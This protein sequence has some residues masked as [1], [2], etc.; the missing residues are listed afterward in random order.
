M[1][2]VLAWVKSNVLIVVFV[3][4]VLIVLPASYV[5]SRAWG[6]KVRTAQETKAGAEM[7]KITGARVDYSL[8][9]FDPAAQPVTFKAEPN[10]RLTD[11][12]R[13]KREE[14]AAQATTVVQRAVDFN[15]GVGP[16]AL[17]VFRREHRP[18]VE[19]LFGDDAAEPIAAELRQSMGESWAAMS[20][21]D[22]V[23][24]V[25]L[26]QSE[27]EK[28]RFYEME[29]R[30]LGKRG[31]PNPYQRLLDR[32]GAGARADAVRLAGVLKDMEIRE[33]EKITAGKRDLTPE[34]L[35]NLQKALLER[36][37]GE[38]QARAREVSV[39]ANLE[40]F[41]RDTKDGSSIATG[42]LQAGELAPAPL[43]IYQWDYWVLSD[44]LAAVRLANSGLDGK[45]TNVDQSAVKRL[46]S[47][48][49]ADPEGLYEEAQ[50]EIPG[51]EPASAT[52]GLVPLNP[53]LSVTGRGM[54]SWNKVY[55]VRRATITAIVASARV[56]EFIDAIERANFMTVT[57]LNLRPVDPYNEL[58]Q[59]YF[60]GPDHL[61]EATLN[62]E[63]VWLREWTAHFMPEEIKL[64]LRF[65]EPTQ[66]PAWAANAPD[67]E[68]N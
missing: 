41:P 31:H 57:G 17:A 44:L 53:Q 65:P 8:P 28:Q 55:D 6:A 59:G 12:F 36:R 16:D 19:R 25:R 56:A 33:T 24:A 66:P 58:Q 21:E 38:Y 48:K 4:I 35:A 34:E 47:I 52:P 22:R 46:V 7:T 50:A 67:T 37:M 27:V 32:I 26:R 42:S 18:M 68:T 9:T 40:V 49:V 51:T 11:W 14:L 10:D 5:V 60:H 29:D 2:N 1:K 43:F 62:V 54:G 61:V 45:P 39:Y 3:A 64:G 30:L 13:Q 20:P 23:K 15:R 63:S